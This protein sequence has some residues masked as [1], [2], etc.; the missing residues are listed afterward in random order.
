[1][2]AGSHREGSGIRP[3]P[4]TT[5]TAGQGPHCRQP[6]PWGDP[7]DAAEAPLGCDNMKG[8]TERIARKLTQNGTGAAGRTRVAE[9]AQVRRQQ[10]LDR[11]ELKSACQKSFRYVIE[12]SQR[13]PGRRCGGG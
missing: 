7:C 11:N 12:G 1:L 6:T 4:L 13:E 3:G 2:Q 10:R 8:V 9:G 5:I